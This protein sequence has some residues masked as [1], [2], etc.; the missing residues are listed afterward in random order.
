MDVTEWRRLGEAALRELPEMGLD[1][2][3]EDEVRLR[4]QEALAREDAGAKIAIRSVLTGRPQLRAW[5]R[6]RVSDDQLR[7]G[8]QSSDQSYVLGLGTNASGGDVVID[9]V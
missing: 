3:T 6:E 8:R 5:L 7:S 4:L 9:E 1:A 2:A